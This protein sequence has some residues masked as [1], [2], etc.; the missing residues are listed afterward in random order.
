MKFVPGFALALLSCAALAACDDGLGIVGTGGQTGATVRFVNATAA[1]VDLTAGGQIIPGDGHILAGTSSKCIALTAA[2]GDLGVRAAGEASDIPGFTPEFV[3]GGTYTVIVFPGLA[4]A[5]QIATLS[6]AFTP[7]SGRSGLRIF[8]AI[9]SAD[10]YDVY[11][12]P[13][14]APLGAASAAGLG[15]G[16]GT[17]FFEVSAGTSQLRLTFAATQAVAIDAGTVTLAAGD[18]PTLVLV[19]PGSSPARIFAPPC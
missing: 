15:F 5:T 3:V 14:G 8:D 9:A 16:A 7:A 11:L 17:P 4:G 13:P 10:A 2:S 19:S 18:S 1:P 6:G 12:T